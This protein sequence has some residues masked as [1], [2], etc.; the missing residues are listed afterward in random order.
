MKSADAFRKPAQQGVAVGNA[1]IAGQTQG[2]HQI[3]R[4]MDGSFGNLFAV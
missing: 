2:S 3:A 4:R 1:L